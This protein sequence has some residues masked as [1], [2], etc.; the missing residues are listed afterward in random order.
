MW[1]SGWNA[2]LYGEEAAFALHRASRLNGPV[3]KWAMSMSPWIRRWRS[4][5]ATLLLMWTSVVSYSRE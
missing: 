1:R 5:V 2:A 3:P 4:S